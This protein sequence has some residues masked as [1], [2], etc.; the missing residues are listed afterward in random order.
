MASRAPPLRYTCRF[1][2]SVNPPLSKRLRNFAGKTRFLGGRRDAE[3]C[4]AAADVY[5][6]PSL[7]DPFANSTLEA[8]ASGLP[9]VTT[10]TNGA[11][12]V[13]VFAL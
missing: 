7:Y 9:V 10:T 2:R 8:L 11:Q 1:D 12:S 5:A 13:L 6:L 4:Y 3:V